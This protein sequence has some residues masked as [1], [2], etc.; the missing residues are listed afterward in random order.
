[1]RYD[2]DIINLNKKEQ[3]S[4]KKKAVV[5]MPHMF[6]KSNYQET[7]TIN[8]IESMPQHQQN[9][10]RIVKSY[11]NSQDS[12]LEIKA[13]SLVNNVKGLLDRQA[14]DTTN[15]LYEYLNE[16]KLRY[17]HINEDVKDV[18]SNKNIE[19]VNI[20]IE[21]QTKNEKSLDI[22]SILQTSEKEIL[23]SPDQKLV[24]KNLI[25]DINLNSGNLTNYDDSLF[26]R[27]MTEIINESKEEDEEIL[28]E[29]L[30]EDEEIHIHKFNMTWV[31]VFLLILVIGIVGYLYKD[32]ILDFIHQTFVFIKQFSLK[33]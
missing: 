3:S 10:S 26:E 9:L 18:E 32:I 14:S 8:E 33:L 2:E 25:N 6:Q 13:N 16:L 11:Q 28:I 21:N 22:N 17:V 30:E 5:K 7:I 24:L 19:I 29:D 4:D 27:N 20:D 31:A 1:M 15:E 12:D 23:N